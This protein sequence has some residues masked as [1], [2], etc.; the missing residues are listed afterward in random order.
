ME[1]NHKIKTQNDL[2]TRQWALYNRLK[3]LYEKDDTKWHNLKDL[4]DYLEI[5]DG[6]YDYVYLSTDN[7]NNTRARRIMTADIQAIK[8]SDIIQK[9]ILSGPNG[10]KI[11]NKK[12]VSNELE[13]T[14]NSLL[15]SLKLVN[16][17]RKKAGLDGQY[18][19]VLNQEREIVEVH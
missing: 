15:K 17:Q 14:K 10:V 8:D 7:F 4:C 13:K 6:I 1:V 12:E 3:C 9:V 19:I 18:R 16:K 11:A 2:N 5:N